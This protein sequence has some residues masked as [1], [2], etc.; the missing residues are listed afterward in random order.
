MRNAFSLV[1]LSIVLVILGLLTGGILAGQSLIRASELR[2]VTTES[3]Q[4]ITAISQFRDK[5]MALPGDMRNAAQFWNLAGGTTEPY[6]LA[7]ISVLSTDPATCNGDGDGI[8]GYNATV[9]N[10]GYESFHLWKHL[11]NAGL[12]N[13]NYTGGL[14]PVSGLAAPGISTPGSKLSQGAWSIRFQNL[15]ASGSNVRFSLDYG[16]ALVYG[17]ATDQVDTRSPLLS[18]EESW[19]IDMKMDD[20]KAGTGNWITFRN[21]SILNHSCTNNTAD[22]LLAEYSV[23]LKGPRCSFLIK[24]GL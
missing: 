8:I 11:S 3:T 7:C 2:S 14:D 19:N 20:G 24:T 6:N 13:G 22:P 5:Y 16:N 9:Y 15:A 21:N 18:P 4:Y 1:E 10:E 17:M 12:I 23:T